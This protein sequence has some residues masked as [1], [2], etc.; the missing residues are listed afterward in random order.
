RAY[1][2]KALVNIQAQRAAS[3]RLDG[4]ESIETTP[5]DRLIKGLPV[6]GLRSVLTLKESAFSCEGELYL[7]GAVMSRFFGLYASI[8]SFHE[9][10]VINSNNSERYRWGMLTGEQP[11]I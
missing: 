8:N 7:F 2:F 5:V 6:R 9:L 1:D 4:I 3:L 11:L 10:E